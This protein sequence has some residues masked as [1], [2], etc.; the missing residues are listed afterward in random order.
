MPW[1]SMLLSS[2][3]KGELLFVENS[4]RYYYEGSSLMANFMNN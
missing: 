4:M 3:L 1:V 2:Q